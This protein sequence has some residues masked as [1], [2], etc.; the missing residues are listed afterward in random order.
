MP[1]KFKDG[2]GPQTRGHFNVA[3]GAEAAKSPDGWKLKMNSGAF[4]KLTK[5]DGWSIHVEAEDATAVA[6]QHNFISIKA[7]NGQTM[8]QIHG[9][10]YRREDGEYTM[11]GNN[12]SLRVVTSLGTSPSEV[13]EGAVLYTG[14]FEEV[15]F[16]VGKAL[17]LGQHINNQNLDYVLLD[18]NSNSVAHSMVKIM[19]FD[20]PPHMTDGILTA[21]GHDRLLIPKDFGQNS[22]FKAIDHSRSSGALV[23][24]QT[25]SALL[26]VDLFKIE[27][28]KKQVVKDGKPQG[29]SPKIFDPDEPSKEMAT[30]SD[31]LRIQ[32]SAPG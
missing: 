15:M 30:G 20:M 17:E 24:N 9:F 7:P 32:S 12:N 26:M 28:V 4:K 11:V 22:Q 5:Q 14:S 25:V 6:G 31:M 8:L 21:I 19:G 13:T 29:Y 16:R 18:Q 2:S 23:S 1:I 10:G 27:K 3:S